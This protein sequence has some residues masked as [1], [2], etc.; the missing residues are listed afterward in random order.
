MIGPTVAV[1]PA[2]PDTAAEVMTSL[3]TVA[4][5]TVVLA[6]AEVRMPEAAVTV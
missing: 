3:L 5:D 4:A 1:D 6:C 2:V